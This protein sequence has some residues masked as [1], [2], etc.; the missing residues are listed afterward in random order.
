MTLLKRLPTIYATAC[1]LHAAGAALLQS[2]MARLAAGVTVVWRRQR[3]DEDVMCCLDMHR[4][5]LLC[6]G[7]TTIPVARLH[8]AL[9]H[10]QLA[11]EL[12]FAAV[13]L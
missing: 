4:V 2:V 9:R 7:V 13:T 10:S 6:Q 1:L 12:H 8:A 11:P 3:L 5:L